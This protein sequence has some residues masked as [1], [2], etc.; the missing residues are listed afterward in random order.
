MTHSIFGS[1]AKPQPLALVPPNA[2]LSTRPTT[3]EVAPAHV[4]QKPTWSSSS[5]VA[6]L[7]ILEA[8]LGA[9]ETAATG[10]ARKERELRHVLG[11]LSVFESRA[12]H[13][14]L[15]QPKAGDA[16]VQAFQ[17]LTGERR[18]RLIAFIADARRR[19]AVG[20]R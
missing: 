3:R 17:R 2:P 19:E 10:F 4:P 11:T 12:L 15:A 5:D 8:P 16:L 9:G 1:I 18:S 20:G 7:A 13:S 14:R 6:L